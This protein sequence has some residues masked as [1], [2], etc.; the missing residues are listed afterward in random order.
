M[1]KD[2]Y[3]LRPLRNSD[4]TNAKYANNKAFS[5]DQSDK[6][7]VIISIDFQCQLHMT[8]KGVHPTGNMV[9]GRIEFVLPKP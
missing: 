5:H 2:I 1:S 7:V 9:K 4:L 3:E 6:Y 8:P